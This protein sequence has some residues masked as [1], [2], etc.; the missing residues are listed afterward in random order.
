MSM[1]VCNII[2]IVFLSAESFQNRYINHVVNKE[3]SI[4]IQNEE[5]FACKNDNRGQLIYKE[6][7]GNVE[8]CLQQQWKKIAS[9]KTIMLLYYYTRIFFIKILMITKSF[10]LF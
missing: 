6:N 5:P 1:K 3:M 2:F 10:N 9:S 4:K 8:I 7:E